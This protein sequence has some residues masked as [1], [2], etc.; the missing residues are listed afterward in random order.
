M[1]KDLKKQKIKATV[2]GG[3]ALSMSLLFFGGNVLTVEAA[4][5]LKVAG[6]EVLDSKSNNQAWSYDGE[7][8]TIKGNIDASAYPGNAIEFEGDLTIRMENGA[9]IITKDQSAIWGK[10]DGAGKSNLVLTGEADLSI[11]SQA[12]YAIFVEGNIYK[13]GNSEIKAVTAAENSQAIFAGKDIYVEG[14]ALIGRGTNYGIRANEGIYVRSA[15]IFGHGENNA[16]IRARNI[17][18]NLGERGSAYGKT[19]NGKWG[20]RADQSLKYIGSLEIPVDGK[21]KQAA[22]DEFIVTDVYGEAV[23][24]VEIGRYTR[25]QTNLTDN[26][27]H[28]RQDVLNSVNYKT[29]TLVTW[30]EVMMALAGLT[31]GDLTGEIGLE[32]ILQVNIQET[33]GYI[34]ENALNVIAGKQGVGVQFLLGNGV[35]VVFRGN[36][37]GTGFV[38]SSFVHSNTFSSVNGVNE[39]TIDF[40][41]KGWIGAPAVF[42]I[43]LDQAVPGNIAKVYTQDSFGKRTDFGEYAIEPTGSISL[44]TTM[45]EKFVIV[46]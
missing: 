38:G 46:Y 10:L 14:G 27:N 7:V 20:I 37:L 42:H 13:K 41:E 8:L 35:S 16:G 32:T 31:P 28:L 9:Q 15:N 43:N 34:K 26:V 39:K 11:D 24:E 22:Y 36:T 5:N 17:Q 33:S 1:A 29:K 6:T 19:Y 18:F 44:P 4:T 40:Q 3:V 30:E 23:K 2:I 45:K 21:I 25:L 12:L